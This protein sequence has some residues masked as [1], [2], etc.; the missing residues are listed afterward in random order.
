MKAVISASVRRA[1]LLR[2]AT[3]LEGKH[4]SRII[5][6]RRILTI[7]NTGATL[8]CGGYFISHMSCIAVPVHDICEE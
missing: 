6:I 5:Q 4:L 1:F 3:S 7:R 2:N 8:S